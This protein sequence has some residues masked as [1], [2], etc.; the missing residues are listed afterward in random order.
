[1]GIAQLTQGA[2]PA[3]GLKPHTDLSSQFPYLGTP[4]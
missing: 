3:D 4:H 1:M 2:V